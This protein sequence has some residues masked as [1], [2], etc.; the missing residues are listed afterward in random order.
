[1][2][3]ART[4]KHRQVKMNQSR[5]QIQPQTTSP[6]SELGWCHHQLGG[7]HS[8][9]SNR[10]GAPRL[11]RHPSLGALAT[12][13][14]LGEHRIY[15]L[16]HSYHTVGPSL[17]LLPRPSRRNIYSVSPALSKASLI[18]T[19][20]SANTSSCN[21]FCLLPQRQHTMEAKGLGGESSGSSE[22]SFTG[23]QPAHHP[24]LPT[25]PL[26]GRGEQEPKDIFPPVGS[27]WK[28]LQIVLLSQVLSS[29]F[30]KG[31]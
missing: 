12:F 10:G 3:P 29:S 19:A 13:A 7:N 20:T 6:R 30:C 14:V 5:Q 23:M 9:F 1:M 28:P 11:Q 25:P 8:L 16:H 21:T 31:G 27:Q 15:L 26:P 2:P 18:Y 24:V 17:F 4:A 22:P